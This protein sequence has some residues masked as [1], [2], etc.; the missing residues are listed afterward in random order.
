MSC[1]VCELYLN[2]LLR[3]RHEKEQEGAFLTLERTSYIDKSGPIPPLSS[4]DSDR[5]QDYH[6]VGPESLPPPLESR[7]CPVSY[8]PQACPAQLTLAGLG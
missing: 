6:Q 2:K 8:F 7:V 4:D 5:C 3:N 1:V